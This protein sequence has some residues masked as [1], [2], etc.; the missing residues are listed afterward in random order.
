MQQ[1]IT[2]IRDGQ[3]LSMDEM[4]AVVDAIMQGDC[5]ED[6]IAEFLLALRAISAIGIDSM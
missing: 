3:S 2:G 6:R 4:A 5:E 1:I